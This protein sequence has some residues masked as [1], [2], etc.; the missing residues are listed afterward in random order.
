MMYWNGFGRKGS[1]KL[2][3]VTAVNHEYRQDSR[4]AC[5]YS[6]RTQID[7]ATVIPPC[8]VPCAIN[9]KSAL[10]V[11]LRANFGHHIKV[12]IKYIVKK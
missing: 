7:Q 4:F 12:N 1:W 6:N 10:C 11:H 3:G 2:R 5:R 9:Q 8:W